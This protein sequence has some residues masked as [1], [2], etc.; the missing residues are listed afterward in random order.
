MEKVVETI[1]RMTEAAGGVEW[2]EREGEK[3]HSQ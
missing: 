1:I 3:E 2:E